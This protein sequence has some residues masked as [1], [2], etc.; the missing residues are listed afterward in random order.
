MMNWK[1]YEKDVKESVHGLMVGLKENHDKIVVADVPC[2]IQE[3]APFRYKSRTYYIYL[4]AH[5]GTCY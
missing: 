5:C 2:E 1:L 3:L 4:P